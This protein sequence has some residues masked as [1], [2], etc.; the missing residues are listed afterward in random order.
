MSSRCSTGWL[1]DRVVLVVGAGIADPAE[2][3]C[4]GRPTGQVGVLPAVADV[5]ARRSRR[6]VARCEACT[7]RRATRRG[8][9][10]R[11]VRQRAGPGFGRAGCGSS[12]L[13]SAAGSGSRRAAGRQVGHRSRPERVRARRGPRRRTTPRGGARPGSRR[14][15]GRRTSAPARRRCGRRRCG[16]RPGAG[17]RSA[18][19]RL[20]TCGGVAH[21]AAG[22]RSRGRPWR[23]R[24]SGRA[25]TVPASEGEVLPAEVLVAAVGDGDHGTDSPG[26]GPPGSL[27][28]KRVFVGARRRRL[29]CP[30]HQDHQRSPSIRATYSRPHAQ[31]P[32]G[33]LGGGQ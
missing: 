22:T 7:R 5:A 2:R 16:L 29:V 31:P 33:K 17:P 8:P 19:E 3:R 12:Q 4:R 32:P 18:T 6:G 1:L 13:A 26:H 10:R 15:G 14:R 24:R 20:T 11:G 23:R 27:F 21:R 9:G 30:S 28:A 25:A